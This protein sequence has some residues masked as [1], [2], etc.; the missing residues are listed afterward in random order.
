MSVSAVSASPIVSSAAPSVSPSASASSATPAQASSAVSS[1]V[2]AAAPAAAAAT[3]TPK[4]QR[5][6][7]GDYKVANPHSSHVK[8]KDGDYKP[9][10]AATSAAAQSSSAVQVLL[11]S[12]K[13]GG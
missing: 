5:A 12:L 8:D 4:L 11:N 9:A 10:G 3:T 1:S 6:A 13:V 2:S 7:D